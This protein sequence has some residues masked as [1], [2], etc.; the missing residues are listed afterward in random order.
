MRCLVFSDTKPCS[1]CYRRLPIGE[2]V[3]QVNKASGLRSN[4]KDCRRAW[5]RRPAARALKNASNVRWRER[6]PEKENAHNQVKNALRRGALT[7]TGCSAC[8]ATTA[9]QGHH[10][11]G[12]ADPLDVVWLCRSCHLD[13]HKRLRGT[14]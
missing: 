10:H 6:Y 13:E 7:K 11:R 9:I 14:I 1:K 8:G 3:R 4:C 2:F 5:E 12:Y